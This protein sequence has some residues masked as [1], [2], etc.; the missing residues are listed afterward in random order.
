MKRTE[1]T[2]TIMK[3]IGDSLV[4]CCRILCIVHCCRLSISTPRSKSRT[5]ESNSRQTNKIDLRDVN[6][7]IFVYVTA[8][9]TISKAK[10]HR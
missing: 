4:V 8:R 9:E 1:L 7:N 10:T 6:F 2:N 5:Q 3:R